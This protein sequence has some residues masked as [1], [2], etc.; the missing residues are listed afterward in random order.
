MWKC[1]TIHGMIYTTFRYLISIQVHDVCFMVAPTLLSVGWAD[2]V[3]GFDARGLAR[4]VGRR[5]VVDGKCFLFP[6]CDSVGNHVVCLLHTM[7]V[8]FLLGLGLTQRR[9]ATGGIVHG[10]GRAALLRYRQGLRHVTAHV[11]RLVE[12]LMRER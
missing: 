1:H 8:G 11:T 2:A 10:D 9:W 5:A 3:N 12:Q 7:S 6:L 4:V